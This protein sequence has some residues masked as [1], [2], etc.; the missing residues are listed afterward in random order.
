MIIGAGRKNAAADLS[1]SK[2]ALKRESGLSP[3]LMYND[4]PNGKME[5]D[6]FT[7]LALDRFSGILIYF[8]FFEVLCAIEV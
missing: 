7:N 8:C 2:P 6:E 3:L 5:F 1:T 4:P